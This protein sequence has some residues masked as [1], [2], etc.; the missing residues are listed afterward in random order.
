MRVLC[1]VLLLWPPRL[2]LSPASPPVR[3]D[4]TAAVPAVCRGR[5]GRRSRR[6]GV[7]QSGQVPAALRERGRL[8]MR[9][10]SH[11]HA[12]VVSSRLSPH[13]QLSVGGQRKHE[14]AQHSVASGATLAQSLAR[15]P[16]LRADWTAAVPAVC[17]GRPGRP[18]RTPRR[19]APRRAGRVGRIAA[20]H[21]ALGRRLMR[22]IPMAM[23]G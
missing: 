16:A 11:G 15:P 8:L 7:R 2:S 9:K 12:R 18:S 13:G 17:R 23:H 14:S 19:P 21:R 1:T 4:W 10:H 5:P 20:A 22:K 3:A 6:R